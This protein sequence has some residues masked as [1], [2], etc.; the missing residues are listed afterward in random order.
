MDK[1]RKQISNDT[2][3]EMVPPPPSHSYIS[4][5]I[6]ASPVNS[7]TS[8]RFCA[9]QLPLTQCQT[10]KSC[11]FTIILPIHYH[12]C[13]PTKTIPSTSSLK[14]VPELESALITLEPSGPVILCQRSRTKTTV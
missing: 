12:L 6:M 2:I 13:L 10:A 3:T 4:Y 11:L 9:I 8:D 14:Y 7:I 1:I 5:L